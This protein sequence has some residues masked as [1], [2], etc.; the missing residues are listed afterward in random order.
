MTADDIRQR[1]AAIAARADD[2]EAAH[3]AEDALLWDFVAFVA[4]SGDPTFAVLAAEVA[5]VA[6]IRFP[7]WCA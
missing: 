2:P 6:E 3:G 7:R 4:A 1:V 5:K